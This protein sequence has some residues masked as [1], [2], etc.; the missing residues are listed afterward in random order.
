M[1]L[2]LWK[3][4]GNVQTYFHHLHK[5]KAT[6]VATEK[7]LGEFEEAFGI[8]RELATHICKDM[9]INNIAK[10]TL[11]FPKPKVQEIV[12]DKKFTLPDMLGTVGRSVFE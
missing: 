8:Q 7:G 2:S 11:E 6:Y 5:L 10:M 4:T 9:F 12:K 3:A 1:A